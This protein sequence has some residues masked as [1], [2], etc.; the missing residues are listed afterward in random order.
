MTAFIALD[1]KGFEYLHKNHIIDRG[2]ILYIYRTL[3]VE[4]YYDY[5]KNRP[6]N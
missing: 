2:Q 5:N 1:I 3:Q 6:I 4:E